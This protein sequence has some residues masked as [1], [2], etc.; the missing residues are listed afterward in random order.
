MAYQLCTP[1]LPS[2]K[3][4]FT[5]LK[6]Y[7]KCSCLRAMEYEAMDD[8]ILSGNGL[9]FGGG[10]NAR[11]LK[12]L[13]GKFNLDSVNIDQKINPT[14]LTKPGE[15]FPSK[16]SQYDFVISLNTL[17][18]IYNANF[19]LKEIQ[20]VLKPKGIAY[21]FVPFMLRIHAH[22]DDFFRATPSWWIESY[23]AAGFKS[24]KITP[25]VWGKRI[26]A[27][28]MGARSIFLPKFLYRHIC[29]LF[30][31]LHAYINCKFLKQNK[32]KHIKR[33]TAVSEGW[34]MEIEK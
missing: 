10:K 31:T 22:P 23:K 5:L 6:N 20:R 7:P 34:F 30:D 4:W 18:H 33:I 9:D 17:E 32:A 3:R 26:T 21:I 24:A 2:F 29:A 25:L 28:S 19:V 14:F 16:D 1:K 8:L 27:L 13:H 15:A 11:Y 12:H